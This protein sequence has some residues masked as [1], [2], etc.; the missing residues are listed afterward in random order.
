MFGRMTHTRTLFVILVFTVLWYPPSASARKWKDRTGRFEVE[1]ELVRIEGENVVLRKSDGTSVSV[2]IAQLSLADRGFIDTERRMMKPA[3]GEDQAR[4]V[5]R[6]RTTEAVEFSRLT[7]GRPVTGPSAPRIEILDDVMDKFMDSINC[8]AASLAIT[9]GNKL[10]Y[11]RGY[12]WID[13]ASQRP[14][15]PDTP[16]RISGCTVP[17][18][19]TAI[20]HLIRT[21]RLDPNLRVFPYLEIDPANGRVADPRVNQITVQ[22]L[23]EHKGGFDAGQSFDPMFAIDRIKR[24]LDLDSRV[25]PVDVIRFML[26]QPLQFNP[27]ERSSV[28]NYGNCVLGRVI[29]KASGKSCIDYLQ[30]SIARPLGIEDRRTI[31]QG[32]LRHN[33]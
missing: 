8:Q 17:F 16:M 20:K 23:L 24:D 18:T 30:Q 29:E 9:Y 22:H 15:L 10:L 31:Q 27:G 4:P 13:E 12:G 32:L 28:S 25:T 7:S 19:T 14:T 33:G 11:S 3:H 21:R 26:T 1:A 6:K 2:P 5:G